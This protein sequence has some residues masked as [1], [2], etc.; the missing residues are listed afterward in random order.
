LAY[1]NYL[2]MKEAY[3]NAVG[4]VS[5][6]VFNDSLLSEF[7]GIEYSPFKVPCIFGYVFC[8]NFSFK[9]GAKTDFYLVSRKDCRRPG[10]RFITRGLDMEGNAANYVETEHVFVHYMPNGP[11]KIAS[12]VQVRGSIPLI[13][14]MKPNLKWSP[15][16]KVNDDFSS[17]LVAAITHFKATKEQ[18]GPQYLVNLI[19]KKGSQKRI[20]D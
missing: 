20:G 7:S 4:N 1:Q 9:I 3:P 18:Y 12:Y 15:P 13:W 10:R 17:S 5:Q 16:V 8:S 2:E 11:I 19:D 14:S 6:Y